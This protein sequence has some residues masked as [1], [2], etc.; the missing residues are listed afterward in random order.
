[1]KPTRSR[2]YYDLKHSEHLERV[3]Y[4]NTTIIYVFSSELYRKKFAEG[5]KGNREKVNSSLSNRFNLELKVN[6]LADLTLY[7]KVEKRGFYLIINGEHIECQNH[8]KLDGLSV[9]TNS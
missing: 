5:I 4:R 2:V 1:M 9:M 7:S 8:V 6:V 3:D